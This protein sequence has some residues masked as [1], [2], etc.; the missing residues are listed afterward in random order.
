MAEEHYRAYRPIDEDDLDSLKKHNVKK[1]IVPIQFATIQTMLTFLM[2]V[3]TLTKPVLRVR[4]ADPRSV[5]PARVMELGLDYDYRGNRGYFQMYQWFFNTYRYGY[6]VMRNTWARQVVL[7]QMVK[8]SPSSKFVLDGQEYDVPGPLQIMRDYF[9]TFEGNKWDLID[10]RYFFYDPRVPV[11]RFQ[12]GEFCGERT[13][14]HDNELIKLE[15]DGLF[16]NTTI[17]ETGAGR[18]ALGGTRESEGGIQDSSRDRI[19]PEMSFNLD[20][21]DAKRRGMHINE[22]LVIECIPKDYELSDED[23]PEHW[24]FNLIDGHYITRAEPSPFFKFPYSVCESYPDALASMSQGVMELTEPLA[25]HLNFLFNSHMAN[26]RKALNDMLV[27]DPSRVDLNDLLDP[28]AGKL[29]RLL[30]TAYGT[31]PAAA[32]KQLQ[33]VDVTRGHIEDAKMLLDF[34]QRVTGVNDNLFGQINASRRTATELQGVLRSSGSRM[35]MQADLFSS[36]GVAPLTEMMAITRQMNMSTAQFFEVAG[37]T[38]AE[39]GVSADEIIDGFLEVTSRH[40]HGV[41]SYPAEEGVI[42][43]DR[44][45]AAELMMNAFQAVASSPF[46]M[47]I[48]DPV[49]LFTE[50]IRQKGLTNINDFAKFRAQTQIVPDDQVSEMLSRGKLTPIG[51]PNQGR[52]QAQEGLSVA[53]AFNGAPRVE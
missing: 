41:F 7:K 51:R 14:I 27:V 12:D 2:E 50:A 43:Q 22:T 19:S 42:P 16:F 47:N 40:V 1:I 11:S 15:N 52:T 3:F 45:D 29:I 32:I 25:Q 18:A 17:I 9:T 8:P 4:G 46:M 10:P 6:G 31:D 35:K 26:I 33:I 37:R 48:F 21:T 49:A 23:R 28:R 34:W 36:E 38:A 13:F 30:P 5:K 39:L 44:A 24:I 20:M 53:G